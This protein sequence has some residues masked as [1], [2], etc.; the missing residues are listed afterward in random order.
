MELVV[1][2][3]IHSKYSR[4]TSRDM[5][6]EN[7]ARSAKIKGIDIIATG[8]F[9]HPEWLL[10]LKNNLS[11]DSSGIHKHNG[12]YFI[13]TAEVNNIYSKYQ[14]S[15]RIHNILIAPDFKTVKEVNKALGQYGDLFSDGRPILKL[16]AKK[17][18]KILR[19]INPH[20]FLI[21]AHLWTPWFG[22]LGSATGFDAIEECF[23]E[24]TNNVHAL[25]TGLSSDPAMNWRL[26]SLDKFFLVSN[27]DAHSPKNLGREANVFESEINY[28]E[29]MN[30]IKERDIKKFLYTIEFFPQEGKYH[31]D[32]HRACGQCLSPAE[33]IKKNNKCPVCKKDVTIGVMHRIEELADRKEGYCDEKFVPFKSLIPLR[34]IIAEVK[35]VGPDTKT[36]ANKYNNI[37]A[38]AG[39]EFNA[40]LRIPEPEL[41]GFCSSRVGDGIMKVRN[42]EV[43]IRPGYDGEYGKISIF[44]EKDSNQN[45]QLTLF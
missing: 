26:S 9:T 6:V 11:E 2:F 30:I 40:L 29:I 18:L 25:E 36:V 10:E 42:G 24:E 13:L 32:G 21:P 22:V 7:L 17:M 43:D 16:D 12:A 35:G 27:S 31:Y 1:D 19:S 34:E 39:S 44:S 14:K 3:H 38:R 28:Y 41:R 4:A 15:R 8:D 37:I 33:S 20:I 45:E 23:E 5:N